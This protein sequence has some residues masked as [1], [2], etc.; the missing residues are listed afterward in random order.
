MPRLEI[1]EITCVI[2]WS[3]LGQF[4]D[5]STKLVAM[6]NVIVLNNLAWVQ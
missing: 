5:T 6:N 3:V 1:I 2:Y 4:T